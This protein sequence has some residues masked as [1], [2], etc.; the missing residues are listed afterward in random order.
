VYAHHIS[1]AIETPAQPGQ[2]GPQLHDGQAY[3]A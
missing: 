1:H 3:A 2:A